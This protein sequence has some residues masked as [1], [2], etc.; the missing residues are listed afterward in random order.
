MTGFFYAL[1]ADRPENGASGPSLTAYESERQ[2]SER[3]FSPRLNTFGDDK[4]P[5]M[6]A[7]VNLCWFRGEPLISVFALS[8]IA[9]SLKC[10]SSGYEETGGPCAVIFDQGV[11]QA[12]KRE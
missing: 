2:L 5:I 8:R 11:G 9:G 3:R 10:Q 12:S 7:R 6:G 4:Y 1:V